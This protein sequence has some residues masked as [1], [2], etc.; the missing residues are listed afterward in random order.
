MM[1]FFSFAALLATSFLTMPSFAAEGDPRRGA[2]LYRAC[3]ACHTLEPGLHTTG[4][5]LA[6]LIGRPAGVAD[7]YVRYSPNLWDVGFDWDA[8]A[9]DD[10]LT[11]PEKMA[12]GTYMTYQGIADPQARADLIAFLAIATAPGGDG[13]AVADGLIPEGY[14][15]GVAPDPLA[16]APAS[17]RVTAIRHC[18]DSYFIT[19]GDGTETPYW[20]KNVRLKID[21]VETGPPPGMPVILGAGMQGDRVSVVFASLADLRSLIIETCQ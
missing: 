2:E 7:G 19:S 8:A 16:D 15:R 12:P 18:G 11:D 6:G 20:E 1:R 4:P 10:W 21:S 14:V 5:S 9:L 3:V 17:A 13:K